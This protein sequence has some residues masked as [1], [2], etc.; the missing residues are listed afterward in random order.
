MEPTPK[1]H[2]QEITS[3]QEQEQEVE[4]QTVEEKKAAPKPIEVRYCG[5][6]GLPDDMCEY[7]A[8]PKLCL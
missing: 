3:D 4:E 6:C 2:E 5:R 1:E 8:K 7:S